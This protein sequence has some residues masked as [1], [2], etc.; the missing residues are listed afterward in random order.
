MF[1][2]VDKFPCC[3]PTANR[4]SF[5]MHVHAQVQKGYSSCY[6]NYDSGNNLGYLAFN[7]DHKYSFFCLEAFSTIVRLETL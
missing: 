3:K 2:F 1:T 7:A 4:F 5:A 6:R